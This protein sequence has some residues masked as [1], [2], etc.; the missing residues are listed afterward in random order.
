MAA[1]LE[2]IGRGDGLPLLAQRAEQPADH[3]G[4]AVQGGEPLL[5]GAREA[6]EA[7]D[8]QQLGTLQLRR[9][10]GMTGLGG[11]HDAGGHG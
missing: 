9:D 11:G 4:L 3:L 10:G 5:Q 2:G 1:A 8:L 7:V 6:E